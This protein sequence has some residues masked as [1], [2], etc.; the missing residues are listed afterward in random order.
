MTHSGSCPYIPED[1]YVLLDLAG[2]VIR[3]RDAVRADWEKEEARQAALEAEY[4]EL[5]D[6]VPVPVTGPRPDCR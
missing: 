2:N 5:G 4:E 6:P 1:D 3:D